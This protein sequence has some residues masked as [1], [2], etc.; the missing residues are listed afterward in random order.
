MGRYIDRER[1]TIE[2]ANRRRA[3]RDQIAAA[4][5]ALTIADMMTYRDRLIAGDKTPITEWK[6]ATCENRNTTS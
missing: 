4:L 1:E 2:A 3:R 6:D 5:G